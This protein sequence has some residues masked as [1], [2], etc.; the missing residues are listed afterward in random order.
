MQREMDLREVDAGPVGSG[1]ARSEVAGQ[2]DRPTDGSAGV[3]DELGE[4]LLGE[5]RPGRCR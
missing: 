5:D 2:C 1:L 4:L 3:G